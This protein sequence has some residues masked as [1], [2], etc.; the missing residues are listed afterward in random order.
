MK[1][2]LLFMVLLTVCLFSAPT[3]NDTL[4]QRM[5]DFKVKPDSISLYVK[6]STLG[7]S[8]PNYEKTMLESIEKD[9]RNYFALDDLGYYYRTQKNNPD[10]AIEY[11]NK[12]LAI[13][14]KGT[15]A[16]TN[17]GTAYIYKNDITNAKKTYETF[18]K[19]IPDYPE[20][21]YGLALLHLNL[22]E[23]DKALNMANQA[24][25]RYKNLDAKKYPEEI[26]FKD[27]HELDAEFLIG[28]INYQMKKY[29]T[30]ID[31]FF[32]YLPNVKDWESKRLGDFASLAYQ[33]NEELKKTDTKKYEANKKKFD[34]LLKN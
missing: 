21:Y 10:K 30:T 7:Q 23:F 17:L 9:P 22:N 29:Q 31:G 34:A 20:G 5:T 14:P 15:F 13:Y 26:D 11:Y 27:A 12:S 2:V 18:I 1:K 4:V 8:S 32:N 19:N 25:T 28:Y 6:A 3:R 24:K 33:S 16:Y